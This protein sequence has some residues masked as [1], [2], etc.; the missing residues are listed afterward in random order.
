MVALLEPGIRPRSGNRTR[1]EV[2]TERHQE[3]PRPTREESSRTST[4]ETQEP[5]VFPAPDVVPAGT[6][7]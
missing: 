3:R 6:F 1:P 2:V 7:H 4:T 5:R